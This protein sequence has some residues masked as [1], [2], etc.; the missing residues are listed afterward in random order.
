M[1]RWYYVCNCLPRKGNGCGSGIGNGIGNGFG[2]GKPGN[3]S[4]LQSPQ[5]LLQT[6]A[7]IDILQLLEEIDM[8]WGE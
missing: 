5:V 6:S 7:C 3:G 2:V 1:L 4:P 8:Q